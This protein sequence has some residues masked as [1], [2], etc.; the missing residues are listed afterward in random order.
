MRALRGLFGARF[1]LKAKESA[2]VLRDEF[3]EGAQE[4]EEQPDPPRA[5]AHRERKP[6]EPDEPDR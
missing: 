2:E 3:R 1:L 6:D 5:I 4:A